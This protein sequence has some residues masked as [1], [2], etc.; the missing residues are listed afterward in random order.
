[1]QYETTKNDSNMKLRKTILRENNRF[2][3]EKL[4]LSVKQK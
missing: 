4:W 1:M 2:Q 3:W